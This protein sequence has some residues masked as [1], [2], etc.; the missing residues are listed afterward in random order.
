MVRRGRLALRSRETARALLRHCCVAP[1]PTDVSAETRACA[2]L[3]ARFGLP[4]AASKLPG[5][6]GPQ[7]APLVA[8]WGARLAGLGSATPTDQAV[9]V[10]GAAFNLAVALFDTVVDETPERIAPL[11]AALHPDRLRACLVAGSP[12]TLDVTDVDADAHLVVRLF[13]SVLASAGRRFAADHDGIAELAELLRRMYESE[14][15]QAPLASLAKTLPIVWIGRLAGAGS[16]T[17]LGAMYDAL[18][19]FIARWDDAQDLADD[20]RRGRFNHY[21]SPPG[22]FAGACRYAA[23]AAS[24]RHINEDLER[25]LVATLA[26]AEQC[27]RSRAA[28][29]F[30]SDLLGKVA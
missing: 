15:G 4:T 28:R 8:R 9:L 30:L 25:A 16:G 5:W 18:A 22:T 26:A 12:D 10:E 13:A 21:L 14:L 24:A 2:V 27:G 3:E 19:D 1:G 20:W 11:A 7:R 29:S 23:P 6:D 17:A